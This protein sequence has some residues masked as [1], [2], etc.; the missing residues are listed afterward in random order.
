MSMLLAAFL[1]LIG[2]GLILAYVKAK[3]RDLEEIPA[4]ISDILKWQSGEKKKWTNPSI[5]YYPYFKIY[6]KRQR[7]NNEKS[8][9]L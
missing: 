2:L 3:S 1:I 8:L 6:F 7:K 4:E 9:Q 5:S